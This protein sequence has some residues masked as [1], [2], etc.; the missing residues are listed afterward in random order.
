MRGERICHKH[1]PAQNQEFVISSRWE[2]SKVF[3]M[4]ESNGVILLLRRPGLETWVWRVWKS[5]GPA[6]P[7]NDI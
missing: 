3:A 7:D 1:F 6:V 2:S 5:V 4:S